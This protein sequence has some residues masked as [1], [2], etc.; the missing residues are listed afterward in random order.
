MTKYAVDVLIYDIGS[1]KIN[2]GEYIPVIFTC[3][4]YHVEGI[5]FDTQHT[6]Q[7]RWT[8]VEELRVKLK[9]RILATI[10]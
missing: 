7:I 5:K 8:E 4:E 10:G 6:N 9:N 2:R 3:H 1:E